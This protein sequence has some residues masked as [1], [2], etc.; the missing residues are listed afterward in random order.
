MQ[1]RENGA[2]ELG[3]D[4][5][6][7]RNGLGGGRTPDGVKRSSDATQSTGVEPIASR[8]LRAVSSAASAFVART[9]R[10]A[11]RTASAFVAP[12][13]PSSVA[14]SSARAASLEPSTTS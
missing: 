12:S 10:S 8:R 4:A 9:T 2:V 7:Q 11:P 1:S 13:T 3:L 6:R 14:A 5:L